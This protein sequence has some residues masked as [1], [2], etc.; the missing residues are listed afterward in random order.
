M[1]AWVSFISSK[2][3]PATPVCL[4]LA[5]EPILR[6][7]SIAHHRAGRTKY[8]VCSGTGP[9]ADWYRNLCAQPAAAVQ[10]RNRRWHPTKRL[11]DPDEAA[12]RFAMYET[13]HPK[14]AARLLRSMGNS[15]DGTDEGRREMIVDMPMV[16]FS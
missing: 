16:A 7:G 14:T 9:D 2:R 13:A 11:L 15:Y 6:R 1:K 4:N 10:V 3:S 12:E 8:L 5:D